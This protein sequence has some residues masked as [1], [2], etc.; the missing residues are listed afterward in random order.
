MKWFYFSPYCLPNASMNFS[1][2]AS[3]YFNCLSI[4]PS[5]LIIKQVNIVE[6]SL[7]LKAFPYGEKQW[8]FVVDLAV[9]KLYLIVL[10]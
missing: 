9:L 4:Q 10:I 5:L 1:F 2:S 8:F 6:Q 3:S 7:K